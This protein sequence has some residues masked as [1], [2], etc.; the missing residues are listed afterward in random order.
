LPG[1][2]GF[3]SEVM[4]FLGGFQE[5]RLLTAIAAGGV[6]LTAGYILLTMQRVFLGD[7]K[8]EHEGF[9]DV[10][11]T[12]LFMLV[13]L[14]AAA[15]VFGIFPSIAIDIFATSTDLFLTWFPK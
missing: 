14:A 1:M 15:I 2:S 4:I 13:P 3:I 10:T 7:V 5:L 8:E 12:E 6:V 11:G 9:K